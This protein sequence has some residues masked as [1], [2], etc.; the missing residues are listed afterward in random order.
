MTNISDDSLSERKVRASYTLQFKM[1]VVEWVESTGAS[2]R[3]AAKKYSVDRK[4]IR[5]WLSN[6]ER[7]R[8]AL[9]SRGPSPGLRKLHEGR[10]PISEELDRRVLDHYLNERQH[11]R[12]LGN[13][14]I[15]ETALKYAQLLCLNGF[16]ATSSW[17]TRWQSRCELERGGVKIG[18]KYGTQTVAK[19]LRIAS[20]LLSHVRP[21]D[22]V[23]L[24]CRQRNQSANSIESH[25]LADVYIDYNTPEH[26]YCR[27]PSAAGHMI[28]SK[29][30]FSPNVHSLTFDLSQD[31]FSEPIIE[32][33]VAEMELPSCSDEIVI[34]Q[35]TDLKGLN[36]R[37]TS[38]PFFPALLD[39]DPHCLGAGG[40]LLASRL[41]Q[42]V[43]P[44]E[45]EI[46][47]LDMQ[48]GML[49][50]MH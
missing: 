46:V 47:Y 14:E 8:A 25:D 44:D 33:E 6:K 9:L 12:L 21:S 48:L 7:M 37:S 20:S 11:G 23:N 18:T 15:K 22:T 40:G 41:L 16:K 3:A 24:S 26:N 17:V 35:D 43:F 39:D 19:L 30:D 27:P 29:D 49:H 4:M 32:C 42:P 45:P 50:S 36:G 34:I 31:S 13:K 1:G 38:P 2:V 28:S 5:N 10:S